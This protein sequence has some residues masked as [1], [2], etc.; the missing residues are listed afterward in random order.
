MPMPDYHSFGSALLMGISCA[1]VY[2]QAAE[3]KSSR[4]DIIIGL[5]RHHFSAC[6][7]CQAISYINI[8]RVITVLPFAQ[9][10]VGIFR[11]DDPIIHDHPDGQRN[12]G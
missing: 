4:I 6:N 9:S 11:H 8:F 7:V 10:P 2:F 3:R 1:Y 12:A 5:A